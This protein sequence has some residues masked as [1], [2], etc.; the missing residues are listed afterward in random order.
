MAPSKMALTSVNVTSKK[1]TYK[2]TAYP[3]ILVTLAAGIQHIFATLR[4]QRVNRR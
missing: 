4:T 2:T 3:F 1:A